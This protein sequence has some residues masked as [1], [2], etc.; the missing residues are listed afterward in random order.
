MKFK[1]RKASVKDA[2]FFYELRNE[3]EARKNFFNT[4]NIKY[5][6]NILYLIM[7]S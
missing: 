1:M 7:K 6:L 2:R 5:N 4:K 3:K